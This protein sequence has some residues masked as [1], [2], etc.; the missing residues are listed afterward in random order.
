MG[1]NTNGLRMLQT[2][3]FGRSGRP[4]FSREVVGFLQSSGSAMG[5]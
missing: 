4:G 3:V 2:E 1:I 5:V